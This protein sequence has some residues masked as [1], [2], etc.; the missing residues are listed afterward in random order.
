[1]H[2]FQTLTQRFRT[3]RTGPSARRPRARLALEALD[4]RILPSVT[5]SGG[6]VTGTGG[7]GNDT[8]LVRLDP[9]GTFVQIYENPLSLAFPATFIAPRSAV[10][11]IAIS[12]N[13]GDDSL[14][15]DFSYG[16]PI[17]AGGLSFDGGAAGAHGNT[18][19]LQGT[20][21]FNSESYAAT[22][23][24]SG[25]ITFQ[26][27]LFVNLNPPTVSYANV[28]QITDTAP[29]PTF[30]PGTP[31]AVSPSLGFS[32]TNGPDQI[33]IG[34]G[35]P[36]NGQ[37]T[38]AITN[39]FPQQ[40]VTF[41]PVTLANKGAVTVY[42]L[43][44]ADRISPDYGT[45]PAGVT[46]LTVDA[47]AGSDFVWVV[48]VPPTVPL[49]VNGGDG[50]DTVWLGG[51]GLNQ[52]QGPVT[53]HGGGGVDTIDLRDNEFLTPQFVGNYTITSTTVSRPLFGGLTYDRRVAGCSWSAS[54]SG[55]TTSRSS[56]G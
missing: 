51:N 55:P 12:G 5:A 9:S 18:V 14:T 22:G 20:C 37:A 38:L 10:Q 25:T 24:A 46:S 54:G 53:V 13:G 39:T 34:N 15:I 50:D 49:T 21:P 31:F 7:A 11:S 33:A 2:W 1:M 32:A 6:A 16:N 41:T 23:P 47:G 43:D 45:A 4:N 8:Y 17:P 26:S 35:T 40:S 56:C 19:V 30:A 29:L 28:Q 36:V 44:G 27:G 52:E 48:D 3:R 42:A